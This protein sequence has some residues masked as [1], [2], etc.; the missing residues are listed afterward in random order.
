MREKSSFAG[1]RNPGCRI[2]ESSAS[3]V[4]DLFR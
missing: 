3:M 2:S 1:S 4:P